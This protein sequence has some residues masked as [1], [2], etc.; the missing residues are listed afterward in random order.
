MAKASMLREVLARTGT[1][2]SRSVNIMVKDIPIGDIQ[3]KENVRK[4]YTGIT[5]LAESIRQHGLLQPITVFPDGDQYRVKTGH[6]RLKA[7]QDLYQTEPERFHSIRCIISNAENIAVIQLV[8]N[9]QRE[10]LSQVDLCNALS[11]LREEGLTLKQIAETMGKT[12][13]YIKSLFVGINEIEKKPDLKTL[14][15]DAGI[16]IRDIAETNAITD[17]KERQSLLEQRGKG[18]INRAELRKKT[19]ALKNDGS[20]Q[21]AMTADSNITQ[22][23]FSSSR[24]AATIAKERLDQYILEKVEDKYDDLA[25]WEFYTW[26]FEQAKRHAVDR[27]GFTSEAYKTD[28]KQTKLIDKTIEA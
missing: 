16:T 14:L 28:K 26:L 10:D 18:E 17:R 22:P 15:G 27:S 9:V 8:E 19:Q 20:I 1:R 21:K 11:A 6:R 5:E 2:D 24:T 23:L 3:I 25:L 13:G 12:E 4:E 7:C